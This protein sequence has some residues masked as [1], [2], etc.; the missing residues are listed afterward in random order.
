M[1][2]PPQ[3]DQWPVAMD[4]TGSL[5]YGANLYGVGG[6]IFKYTAAEIAAVAAKTMSPLDWRRLAGEHRRDADRDSYL[7]GGAPKQ[8]RRAAARH[9]APELCCYCFEIAM[10]MVM[11]IFPRGPSAGPFLPR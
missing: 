2:S 7:G 3:L 1:F 4:E 6:D 8:L 5:F 9:F 10:M 11:E